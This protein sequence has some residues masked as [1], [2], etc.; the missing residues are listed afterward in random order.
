MSFYEE[1]KRLARR[2]LGDPLIR[3]LEPFLRWIM[4][5]W[6]MGRR[7]YCPC[8]GAHLRRLVSVRG[9]CPSCGAGQRH[10][11]QWLYLSREH[12]FFEQ[13]Y[14]VLDIS[15]ARHFQHVCLDRSNLKY[16]SLD[17]S[18]PWSMVRADLTVAPFAD[19]SFQVIL[20]SHVLEHIVDDEAAMGEIH[21]LLTAGGFALIQVPITSARTME[22]PGITDPVARERL[23][24]QEDH[25]RR[26]GMDILDRLVKSGLEVEAIPYALELAEAEQRRM[27]LDPEEHLFVCQKP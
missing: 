27:A 19:E 9:L 12:R 4:R 15:P 25:V 3:R 10:R 13:D 20:C 26:Y 8:C 21:R 1:G 11:L 23:F 22:D 7:Y 2:L 14:A 18:M 5:I 6:Y 16:V 24:G 17:L